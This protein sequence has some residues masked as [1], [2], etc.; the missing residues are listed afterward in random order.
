MNR[1]VAVTPATGP[2]RIRVASSEPVR[3]H[4][5]L[6]PVAIRVLGMPGPDGATGAQGPQ[7]LQG[8]PGTL[9][10]GITIDGGNF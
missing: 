9:D 3:V 10:A 5:L 4:A 8:T 1:A 7:G 6:P 2:I